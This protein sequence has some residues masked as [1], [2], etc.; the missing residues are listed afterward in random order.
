MRRDLEKRHGV[1]LNFLTSITLA[2]LVLSA[3]LS[4]R[5]HT[6]GFPYPNGESYYNLRIAGEIHDDILFSEDKLQERYYYPNPFHYFL[7]AAKDI[8][9]DKTPVLFPILLGLASAILFHSLL[10]RLGFPEKNAS[11]A[12]MLLSMTPLFIV[13]YTS[14]STTG[15]V[16]FLSLFALNT[17][18]SR[19][20]WETP[21][22]K[23]GNLS[24]AA[25]IL[26][27]SL[28]SLT[29]FFAFIMTLV[30]I[31]V[32]SI[33]ERRSLKSLI[34]ATLIPL[35]LV[36]PLAIFTPFLDVILQSFDIHALD[37]KE[38]F[39]IFG[40]S[41]GLG[42]FILML[43]FT[44]L[45][46]IWSL[47]KDLRM[48]HFLTLLLVIFSFFSPIMRVY[49]NMLIIVYC[50]VAIKFL[51]YRRWELE[52]VKTGTL[53]LLACALLFSALN[54]ADAL[55]SAQPGEELEPILARL[56]SL[57]SGV[58]LS[59]PEYGFLV[60]EYSAKP[61]LLDEATKYS[62]DFSQ[63]LSAQAGLINSSRIIDADPI[64]QE[65]HAR[66]FLIT[67]EMKE[68]LWEGRE[69]ELL[70]LLK[71]SERFS[72]LAGSDEGVELWSLSG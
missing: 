1:A 18:F 14:L 27:L 43:F 29:S 61:T 63:R 50:V 38:T 9:K 25:S 58:V 46:I 66:Y 62:D 33:Y 6:S 12:V 15:F 3:V 35:M 70:F 55:I 37:L 13:L 2:V 52:I 72:R 48:Y 19:K 31:A 47:M 44:G 60:Q 36:V 65:T 20:Y 53:L 40:A 59:P 39:S 26:L 17:Y 4:I 11:F 54:Q 30:F 49:A 56:K 7:A 28:L 16:V 34:P 21:W 42:L 67:S 51:Y 41:L 24:F 23:M 64:L 10:V 57:P 45:I 71:N 32:F 22:K 69:E 68:T 5:A 8:L